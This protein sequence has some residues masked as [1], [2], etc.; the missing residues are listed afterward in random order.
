MSRALIITLAKLTKIRRSGMKSQFICQ[1]LGL[2]FCL[3]VFAGCGP[4]AF[5]KGDYDDVNRN[6][7]LND[8]W[9]ETDM[10]KSVEELVSSMVAAPVVATAKKP[11]LVMMTKLQNK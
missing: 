10:Q 1:S 11:P 6:N 9:S 3:L 8:Q 4:S 2:A 5:T 7:N